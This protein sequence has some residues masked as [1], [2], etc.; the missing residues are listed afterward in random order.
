MEKLES[1]VYRKRESSRG[2]M[3]VIPFLQSV[4]NQM[5]MYFDI[6]CLFFTQKIIITVSKK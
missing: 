2:P 5:E 4:T 1:G 3:F 6:L